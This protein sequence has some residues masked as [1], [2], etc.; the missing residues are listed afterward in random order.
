MP[1][2][3]ISGSWGRSIFGFLRNCLT[4]FHSDYTSLHRHQQQMS[5]P[6]TSNLHQHE[7]SD[8]IFFLIDDGYFNWSKIKISVYCWFACPWWLGMLNI[9]LSVSQPFEF[10]L[11]RILYRYPPHPYFCCFSDVQFFEFFIYFGYEPSI[12]CGVGEK[13][14]KNFYH[15]VACHFE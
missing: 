3:C 12:E 4:H 7:L 2:C 10:Y 6:S 8:F 5:V 14:K 13:K 9:S 11:L 1:K 15:F